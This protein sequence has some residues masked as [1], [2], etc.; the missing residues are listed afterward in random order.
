MSPA[1][2]VKLPAGVAAAIDKAQGHDGPARR[3]W[4]V[5]IHDADGSEAASLQLSSAEAIQQLAA[6]LTALGWCVDGTDP[7]PSIVFVPRVKSCH[8]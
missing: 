8:P 1:T 3:G 5:C 2:S 7:G 6:D 4:Q